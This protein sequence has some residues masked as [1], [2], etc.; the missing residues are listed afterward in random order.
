MFRFRLLMYQPLILSIYAMLIFQLLH[1]IIRLAKNREPDYYI[2]GLRA[3]Q[4]IFSGFLSFFGL[5]RKFNVENSG[6]FNI[7]Y[8]HAPARQTPLTQL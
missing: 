1:D 8:A 7:L 3:L 2:A 4:A 6:Y 5:M